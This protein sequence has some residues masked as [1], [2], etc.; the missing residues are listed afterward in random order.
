MTISFK[1]K[2]ARS[3]DTV[4]SYIS[5]PANSPKWMYGVVSCT[6]PNGNPQVTE[7]DFFDGRSK[8]TI[9]QRID[10]IR[11]KEYIKLN[12]D[13]ASQ[14]HHV[15]IALSKTKS[16][17]TLLDVRYTTHYKSYFW[18]AVKYAKYQA[19]QKQHNDNLVRLKQ[20]IEFDL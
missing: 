14:I 11:E 7:L 19:I 13:S 16:N 12:L 6:Q 10:E 8:T 3:L 4:W 15:E 1:F 2:V 17:K 20:C 18:N 5:Q 9:L